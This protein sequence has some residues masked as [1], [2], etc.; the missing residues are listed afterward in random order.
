MVFPLRIVLLV[1]DVDMRERV[2]AQSASDC[3]CLGNHRSTFLS[4]PMA[5]PS[6]LDDGIDF[7]EIEDLD[8]LYGAES[9]MNTR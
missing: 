6:E 2:C 5:I 9:D 7:S 1:V 8:S 3:D 4:S